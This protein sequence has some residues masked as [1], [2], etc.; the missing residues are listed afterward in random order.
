MAGRDW[1]ESLSPRCLYVYGGDVQTLS[2]EDLASYGVVDVATV[3]DPADE[4]GGNRFLVLFG[5]EAGV[6]CLSF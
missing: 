5:T 1:K 3:P 4:R 2:A 6:Y